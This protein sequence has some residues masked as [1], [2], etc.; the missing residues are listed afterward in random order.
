MSD[1]NS[2][3]QFRKIKEVPGGYSACGGRLDQ[4]WYGGI[5][6]LDSGSLPLYN[7]KTDKNYAVNLE[8]YRRMEL[9]DI[10]RPRRIIMMQSEDGNFL[11][12]EL[13]AAVRIDGPVCPKEQVEKPIVAWTERCGGG[14]DLKLLY[15]EE[16]QTVVRQSGILRFPQVAM[17]K[18]G[19]I[20][21][22][23]VDDP[24]GST[25]VLVL[26]I[27]GQI[28]NRCLGRKPQLVA[29]SEGYL[30]LTEQA[31]R[32]RITLKLKH[33]SGSNCLAETNISQGDYLFNADLAYSEKEN[34][35]YIAAESSPSFGYG[36]QL[37]QARILYTWQCSSGTVVPTGALPVEK[38]GFMSLGPENLP[39]IKPYVFIDRNMPVVAFRQFRYAGS[40]TFGWD[41][42]WCRC[43]GD[44]W[45]EP[46]RLSKSVGSPDTGFSILPIDDHYVVFAPSLSNEGGSALSFNHRVE[47]CEFQV[48]HG[49]NRYQVSE[50]RKALYTIP[51]SHMDI[52]LDP[53]HLP[54]SYPGRILI[55]GDMHVH[56]TYS[57]CMAA[58][59]GS[60]DEH[61]RFSRDVLGCQVFTLTE[62]SRWT[63]GPESTWVMDRLE[64]LAGDNGII[65]YSTEPVVIK[66]IRHTNWYA[67][68]RGAFERLE[69]VFIAQGHNF[70]RC[71]RNVCEELPFGSVFL[72]RHFH[73][74][75]MDEEG[76]VHSFEP[77]LEVAMEA[78]QGRCNAMI[79]PE[80]DF[81]VFP[82]Q[83]LNAGCKIGLV[84]G[85][86]HYRK[87]TN[88]YCLTG[89]WVREVSAKG[90][91]EALRNR[92]T[93]AM[94]D[95]KVALTSYLSGQPMG[96]AVIMDNPS[97]VRI[98][99]NAACGRPIRRARLI[100]DGKLLPWFEIG[101]KVASFDLVDPEPRTGRHWY[102]PTVEVDT[103]YG[104]D[105]PGYCHASPFF[106]MIH[107]R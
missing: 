4:G 54:G 61:I 104:S 72:M 3:E 78:M 52:A 101:K 35:C 55:W 39:P 66:G 14:W 106:V 27:E 71:L 12:R 90:V 28:L 9:V 5:L 107:G 103:A 48:H 56:S 91:W 51:I 63:T 45:S 92:F 33:C 15:E 88:H 16:I 93:I 89:F 40:K 99:L 1:L 86:D 17:T 95:A 102:V 38:R 75:I 76:M 7:M 62:H 70:Q 64:L 100:R 65:L 21:A 105:S 25:Q 80:G 87:G 94:S 58:V 11:E 49:L 32:N 2:E 79:E 57:K 84:G 22:I 20:L 30:L 69:R 6:V 53:P 77:R 67:L 29:A 59:D 50:K 47:I 82:N 37:G 18:D 19:P 85:T 74:S 81:P 24:D 97:E 43:N 36:S 60:P 34:I 31:S 83:F 10:N 73:G 46:V 98:R 96:N 41:I 68:E 23:E 44:K 13:T 26:N 42:F 8:H